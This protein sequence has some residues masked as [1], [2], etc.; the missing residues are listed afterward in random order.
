MALV[1]LGKLNGQAAQSPRRAKSVLPAISYSTWFGF[2]ARETSLAHFQRRRK[3]V[4]LIA[5]AGF[6]FAL[7]TSAQ[8]ITPAPQTLL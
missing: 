8:A 2:I 5:V 7:A 1:T 6:V 4:R 3:M